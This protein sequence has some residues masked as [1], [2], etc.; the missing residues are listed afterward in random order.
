[1]ALACASAL[2]ICVYLQVVD[3]LGAFKAG[4]RQG[5]V[6]NKIGASDVVADVAKVSGTPPPHI[7]KDTRSD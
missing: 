2:H 6:L 7:K 5:D 1:M 3:G 4:I